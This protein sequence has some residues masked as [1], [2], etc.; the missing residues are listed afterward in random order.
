[1][2]SFWCCATCLARRASP[3]DSASWT[4]CAMR[5]TAR[6]ASFAI[7]PMS[8]RCLLSFARSSRVSFD[9]P[10]A[11]TMRLN[12]D[13]CVCIWKM[14]PPTFLLSAESSSSSVLP[15]PPPLG[16]APE[17]PPP[18]ASAK[19]IFSRAGLN[20]RRRRR[21]RFGATNSRRLE[22]GEASAARDVA[23]QT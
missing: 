19:L 23:A 1:M 16:P 18:Y 21:S 11:S 20:L 5:F 4:V 2:T 8:S 12:E 10:S 9:V 15:P 3:D 17:P 6:L 22:V 13:T 7:P 14:A